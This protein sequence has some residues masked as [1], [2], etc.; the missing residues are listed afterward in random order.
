MTSDSLAAESLNSGG[1]FGAGNPKAA[2][3]KQPSKSTT[4]NTTN[5][6]GATKLDAAVDA[7]AREAQ[8]GWN[9]NVQLNAGSHLGKEAGVGPTYNTNTSSTSNTS[10]STTGSGGKGGQAT[11]ATGGVPSTS[12][13]GDTGVPVAP[14]AAYAGSAIPPESQK[15]KGANLTEGGFEGGEPNASFNSEI[16]SQDD[17]ARL[18]EQK[19]ARENAQSAADA[20]TGAGRQAGI[21]GENVYGKL[22]AEE[23]A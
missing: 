17:P 8:Q 14:T 19:F 11:S 21:D 4:T 2:T 5:T 12:G 10:S 20:G 7:E 23:R 16:G 15:P 6:S 18:A 3:S 1:S 13:A 22:G 9:E